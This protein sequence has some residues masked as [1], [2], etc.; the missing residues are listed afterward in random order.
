MTDTQ[1]Q[2]AQEEAYQLSIIADFGALV[3]A[4]G[5]ATV[6]SQLN[7]EAV[8]EIKLLVKGV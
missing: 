4:L 8:E 2:Q 1:L 6:L 5:P 7:P 3:L